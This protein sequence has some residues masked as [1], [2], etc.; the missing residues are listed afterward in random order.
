VFLVVAEE[1]VGRSVPFVFLERIKEDFMQ[2]YGSSIDEEHPLADDADE[3][4]FLF[5]DRFS[6][7][8]NLD[9]EFGYGFFACWV[10]LLCSLVV[11]WCF[12]TMEVC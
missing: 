9:R 2:R 1:A 8:Y 7:A 4:D 11:L 6:I 10:V 3:D 5:E 12:V